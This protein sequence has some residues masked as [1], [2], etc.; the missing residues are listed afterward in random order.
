MAEEDDYMGM[1]PF[2]PPRWLRDHTELKSRGIMLATF[3]SPF[4][5]WATDSRLSCPQYAVKV[6]DHSD[7]ADIY[8]LLHQLGPAS[9]NHTLPCDVIRDEHKVLIMPYLH[10]VTVA[11]Q[12]RIPDLSALLEFFRQVV[13]G[14]EFLHSHNIAHMDMYSGQLIVAT[15]RDVAQ[16][17]SVE[18][19]KVYIIDYGASQRLLVGPGLQPAVDLPETQCKP[20][21]GMK[22]FDPYSWDIYCTGVLFKT[23]VEVWLDRPVS[24][25]ARWYIRW[26]IGN[27]RGCSG[28]CTCR[29]TARRARQVLAFIQRAVRIGECA[30]W[31]VCYALSLFR[32]RVRPD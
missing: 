25:I 2:S 21:L 26:L 14:V 7:E 13:E 17:P 24:W 16:H 29:P 1:G 20:P 28:V 30:I 8:D 18:A 22:R 9:R 23:F 12:R 11:P 6:V 31:P 5:A 27:E 10:D 15:K 19:G 3:L 32:S 4:C